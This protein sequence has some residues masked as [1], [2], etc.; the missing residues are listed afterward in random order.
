MPTTF[1]QRQILMQ[2]RLMRALSP[3]LLEI[4]DEGHLHIGHP[5]ANSGGSHVKITIASA[6]F[7]NKNALARHRLVY[8]ALGDLI[9]SELHAVKIICIEPS[10]TIGYGVK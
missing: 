6:Q 8:A 9:G 1:E 7:L 3:T 4:V 10:N 5:G 2:Q